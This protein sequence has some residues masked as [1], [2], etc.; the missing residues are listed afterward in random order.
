VYPE[1]TKSDLRKSVKTRLASIPPEQFARAGRAA[2]ARLAEIPAWASCGSV[3][4]F[5]SLKDE[6]DTRPIIEASLAAGKKVF[7]PAVKGD[8][9][10]FRNALTS[11]PLRLCGLCEKLLII[12]PGLA[13][14]EKGGRLG[15]G[16]GFYDRFLASISGRDFFSCGLCLDCQM[17]ESVPA[18]P[19]DVFLDAVLTEK[20][21]RVIIPE[22]R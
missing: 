6:I 4:C 10:E 20:R 7:L 1:K 11:E 13:F 16:R 22:T 5:K 8:T 21:L 12:V 19:H 14:D 18:E 9:M 15:R 2:A 17:V 3:L